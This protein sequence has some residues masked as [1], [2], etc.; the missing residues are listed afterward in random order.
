[1]IKKAKELNL[2]VMVGSMNE[3]TIGS[4]AIAHLLPQIDY[5]DMDGPLLLSEDIAKGLTYDFGNSNGERKTGLGNRNDINIIRLR[6][7]QSKNLQKI[8]LQVLIH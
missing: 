4:A 6:Y 1:M 2:K 3:S 5:V 7:T 8:I